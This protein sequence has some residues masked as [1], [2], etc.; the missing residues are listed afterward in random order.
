[1]SWDVFVQ[2]FPR[3]VKSVVDIP[4]D[5]KPT[6]IGV[7]STIIEK[8]KEIFPRAD[9]SDPSWGRID[10]DDWSIEVNLGAR[11]ICEGFALHV[12]GTGTAAGA[13]AAI[14]QSLNLRAIDPQ[15][16]DFFVAGDE[17]NESFRKWRSYRDRVMIGSHSEKEGNMGILEGAAPAILICVRDRARGIAFYRDTLGLKLTAEDHFAAVFDISG[18]MLRVSTLADFVPHEHSILG[19]RV[20]DVTATVKTLR[21]KGVVFNIYPHFKQDELGIWTVPSGSTHVAWFKDPDG[22]VLSITDV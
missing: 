19:F 1:V 7:C 15:T 16:G 6:S 22:N 21:E 20:K 4:P 14:L 13:V 10:G 2:D 3:D 18:V 11:E 8:I 5:F 9:F 12:R 17:A